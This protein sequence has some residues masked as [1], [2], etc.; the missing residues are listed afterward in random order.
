MIDDAPKNRYLCRMRHLLTRISTAIL[1]VSM[2]HPAAALGA[3]RPQ[4]PMAPAHRTANPQ[5]AATVE[6]FSSP[7]CK[8]CDMA[9]T[10]FREK[11]ISFT[12]Y[13]VDENKAAASR[14]VT[15]NPRGIL[16]FVLINGRRVTGFM[17][18]VYDRL[19]AEPDR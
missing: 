4:P 5:Q 16:P 13:N 10:Y 19:L 1:I 8:Y 15:M 6:I 7:R 18:E 14:M 12:E 2:G 11:R 17:P 3:D 9:K